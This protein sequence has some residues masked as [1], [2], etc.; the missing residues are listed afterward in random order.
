MCTTQADYAPKRVGEREIS[1][2]SCLLERRH[3]RIDHQPGERLDTRAGAWARLS[4]NHRPRVLAARPGKR[5]VRAEPTLPPKDGSCP[6]RIGG[7]QRPPQRRLHASRVQILSPRLCLAMPNHPRGFCR[8]CTP[9]TSWTPY[10]SR[11]NPLAPTHVRG[12]PA[13]AQRDDLPLTPQKSLLRPLLCCA[14]VPASRSDSRTG[15]R[16]RTSC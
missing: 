11:S 3:H 7:R 2:G 1:Q 5:A 6:R 12:A 10:R 14:K 16:T 4:G 9:S 15:R 13:G 8:S